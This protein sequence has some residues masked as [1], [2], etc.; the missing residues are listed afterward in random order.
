MGLPLRPGDVSFRCNLVTLSTEASYAARTMVDYC[1][2][3][4][5]SAEAGNIAAVN[6]H[7]S[8]PELSFIRDQPPSRRL[9]RRSGTGSGHLTP[10]HDIT[11]RAITL[12]CRPANRLSSGE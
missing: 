1:A 5:S 6:E 2:G 3:E 10:P 9:G 8:T 4:I 12:T 7:L 11:G